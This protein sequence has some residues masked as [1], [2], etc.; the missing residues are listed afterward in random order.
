MPELNENAAA[1]DAEENPYGIVRIYKVRGS[2]K[3]LHVARE[4][5]SLRIANFEQEDVE[6][7][8]LIELCFGEG[9]DVCTQCLHTLRSKRDGEGTLLFDAP[10]I[11]VHTDRIIQHRDGLWGIGAMH[12]EFPY[13]AVLNLEL[14]NVLRNGIKVTHQ[15]GDFEIVFGDKRRRNVAFSILWGL[16]R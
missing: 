9:Q 11:E 7:G 15:D 3:R 16:L 14:V 2:N 10:Q 5:P 1:G 6:F 4:C 8:D 12:R 13:S